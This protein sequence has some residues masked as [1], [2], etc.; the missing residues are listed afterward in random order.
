MEDTSVERE[1]DNEKYITNW[2]KVVA[3]FRAYFGEG[4]LAEEATLKEVVLIPKG[5]GDHRDMG[6]VEVVCKVVM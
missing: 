2:Y 3:L 1:M 4:R 5:K 6:L